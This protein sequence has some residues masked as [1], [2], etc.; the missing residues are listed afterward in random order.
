MLHRRHSASRCR[1]IH[2]PA[3]VTWS[4]FHSELAPS[5]Q[6]YF[7]HI[8]IAKITQVSQLIRPD[9]ITTITSDINAINTQLSKCDHLAIH[10]LH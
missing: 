8:S 7:N 9:I 1:D 4:S 10:D 6:T 3:A 2:V 5:H